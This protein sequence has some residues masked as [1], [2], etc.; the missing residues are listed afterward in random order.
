MMMRQGPASKSTAHCHQ[1]TIH[2]HFFRFLT[3]YGCVAFFSGQSYLAS[4]D[5]ALVAMSLSQRMAQKPKNDSLCHYI[6]FSIATEHRRSS[7]MAE[8]HLFLL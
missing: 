2:F 7:L 3:G 1:V 8:L 5:Q 6:F 4:H